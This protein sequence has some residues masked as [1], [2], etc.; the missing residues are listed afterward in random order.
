MSKSPILPLVL[1]L[2]PRGLN[3]WM[4]NNLPPK[5]KNY[6]ALLDHNVDKRL[7][8]NKKSRGPVRTDMLHFLSTAKNPD[9][10]QPA[11]PRDDLL[12]E[13]HLL[14]V[15]GSDTTAVTMCGLF[16][17][18]SHNPRIYDKLANEIR[19]TFKSLDDVVHGPQLHSCTYLRAVIQ[20]SLRMAPAG[21]SELPRVLLKGGMTIDGFFYPEGTVVGT[22]QWALYRNEDFFGSDAY[23]FRPERWIPSTHPD[24]LN[25]EAEVQRLKRG[26]YPFSK[27]PG[28]C[29]GQNLA[30][31]QLS[32]LMARTFLQADFRLAP[33]QSVGEGSPELGWG[34]T[35][36]MHYQLDDI[37]IG[38]REGPIIQFRVR[39]LIV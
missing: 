25:S 24:T 32:L 34:R 3:R 4:E 31:L 20:E 9:T 7:E 18:L 2:K 6:Y 35:D 14:I 23:T 8:L 28:N 12:S 27:G 15:A 38:L 17:F 30:M 10:D 1:W 19:T 36:P 39:S 26:F 22:P 21:P 29:V 13:C 33:G 16:F 37:F 5:M 11:W